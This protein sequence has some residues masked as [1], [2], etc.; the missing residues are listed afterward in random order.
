[1]QFS[2]DAEETFAN[3]LALLKVKLLTGKSL[4]ILLSQ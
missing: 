3:A 2:D 4:A 1:M